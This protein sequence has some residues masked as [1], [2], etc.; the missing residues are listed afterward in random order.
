M[1]CRLC[2]YIGQFFLNILNLLDHALNALLLGDADETV[3]ARTARARNAG[4]HWAFALCDFLAFA[5]KVV[6]FGKIDHDHCAMAL[7]KSVRPNSR[8]ILDLNTMSFNKTPV[9]EV[10][11]IDVGEDSGNTPA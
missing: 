11:V 8:E 7:D 6:T 5:T 4:R 2:M 1:T 3:S 9:S 10:E